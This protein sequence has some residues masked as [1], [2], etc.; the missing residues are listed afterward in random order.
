MFTPLSTTK[1]SVLDGDRDTTEEAAVVDD[2]GAVGPGGA[3]ADLDGGGGEAGEAV[4]GGEVVPAL[5]KSVDRVGS[6]G[7]LRRGEVLLAPVAHRRSD[8][9]KRCV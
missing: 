9:T 4:G 6:L 1:A 3:I 7:L 5:E 8:L 2:S